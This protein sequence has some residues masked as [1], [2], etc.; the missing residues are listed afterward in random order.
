MIC[1]AASQLP[2]NSGSQSDAAG[3][4]CHRSECPTGYSSA[5]CSPAEPTS[6]SPVAGIIASIP[7]PAVQS[8]S[9][10]QAAVPVLVPRIANVVWVPSPGEAT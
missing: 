5:G 8:D 2:P 1:D 4:R 3:S 6:A 7:D 10:I 9:P